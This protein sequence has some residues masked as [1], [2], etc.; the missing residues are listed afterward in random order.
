MA[1]ENFAILIGL[2]KFKSIGDTQFLDLIQ[3]KNDVLAMKTF[4]LQSECKFK[5]ENILTLIDP[6]F[7]EL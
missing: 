7:E 3:A 5:E 1:E 6:T 2:A 4:L